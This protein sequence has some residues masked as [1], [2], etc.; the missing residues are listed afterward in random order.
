MRSPHDRLLVLGRWGWKENL[1]LSELKATF[2][3]NWNPKF[4]FPGYVHN[5]I[6]KK[7][8]QAIY[9]YLYTHTH[10]HSQDYTEVK[11][12]HLVSPAHKFRNLLLAGE[13]LS[14]V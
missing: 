9:T 8:Y 14:K 13:S 7:M 10:T 2:G 6:T 12:R 1:G 11:D 4:V 5:E 3:P